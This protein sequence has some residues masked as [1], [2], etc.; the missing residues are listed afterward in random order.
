MKKTKIEELNNFVWRRRIPYTLTDNGS[1][2]VA[3]LFCFAL[4]LNNEELTELR[5]ISG[6]KLEVILI[7]QKKIMRFKNKKRIA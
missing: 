1:C 2:R 6:Q 4:D 3:I 5:Q 7:Q